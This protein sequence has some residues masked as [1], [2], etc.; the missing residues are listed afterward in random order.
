[1]ALNFK[2]L[3]RSRVNSSGG[4]NKWG[5]LHEGTNV[6]R[7]F[8]FKHTV[9]AEDFDLGIYKES[10]C[11]TIGEEYEEVDR[12]V[13]KH[14]LD[15]G[16]VNCIGTGCPHCKDSNDLLSSSSKGD[17]RAGKDLESKRQYS[18]NAI[19]MEVTEDFP[20]IYTL[21]QSVYNDIL[22]YIDDPENGEDVLGCNGRDFIIEKNKNAPKIVDIYKLKIRDSKHCNGVVINAPTYDLFQEPSLNPGYSSKEELVLTDD[23]R[24]TNKEMDS[25]RPLPAI[26]VPKGGFFKPTVTKTPI[27]VTKVP[28][29]TG[30]ISTPVAIRKNKFVDTPTENAVTPLVA[31]DTM[32][33]EFDVGDEVSY[34]AGSRKICGR[35][36]DTND[37]TKTAGVIIP[38]GNTYDVR[39]DLLTKIN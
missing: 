25:N 26:T 39:L 7:I 17:K 15:D 3:E 4:G 38:D 5:K 18:V 22:E 27:P 9:C 14:F 24:I 10:D 1:M 30:R 32:P 31:V 21:P 8:P 16:Q 6:L 28:V 37:A 35:I 12:E 2:R 36:V 33:W 34:M 13:M 11:V 23:D 19:N 20:R 29:T